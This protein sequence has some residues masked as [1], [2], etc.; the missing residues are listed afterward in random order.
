MAWFKFPC[1]NPKIGP[2]ELCCM[3]GG[4]GWEDNAALNSHIV[5]LLLFLTFSAISAKKAIL[6]MIV[7]QQLPYI[8]IYQINKFFH[9]RR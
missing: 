2:R 1:G 5:N 7:G 3:Q 6:Y 9:F 8:F 4:V